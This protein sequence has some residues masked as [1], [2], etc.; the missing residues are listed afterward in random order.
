MRVPQHFDLHQRPPS[1]RP[2]QRR[3]PY[4]AS[5]AVCVRYFLCA[6][7]FCSA[8]QTTEGDQRSAQFLPSVSRETLL[9]RT[10]KTKYTKE[11]LNVLSSAHSGQSIWSRPRRYIQWP[12]VSRMQAIWLSG[13]CKQLKNNRFERTD[14]WHCGIHF[15]HAGMAVWRGNIALL[16]TIEGSCAHCFA[17][18][19]FVHTG[20]QPKP[21]SFRVDLRLGI[22]LFAADLWLMSRK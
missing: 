2:A 4:S 9:C 17:G 6:D 8:S 22:Y 3:Q 5:I 18:A 7:P 19:R 20:R 1:N 11:S 13:K 14:V 21:V 10:L 16:L 15:L 12:V